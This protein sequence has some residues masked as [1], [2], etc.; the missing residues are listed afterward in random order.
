MAE[1]LEIKG[2][3]EL[4]TYLAEMPETAQPLIGDAMGEGLDAIL[5]IVEMYPPQPPRDRAKTFNTYV[6]GIGRFPLSSFV[7]G[8]RK[9]RRAYEGHVR[10]TSEDLGNQWSQEIEIGTGVVG[11]LGNPVSYADYVQ[12]AKQAAHHAQTGWVTIEEA[13]E[14]ATPE[15]MAAFEQALDRLIEKFNQGG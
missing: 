8:K 12:G 2:F 14:Q 11:T 3:D 4:L 1:I 9:R 15:I 7:E 6:R 13:L 10:Y 5:R